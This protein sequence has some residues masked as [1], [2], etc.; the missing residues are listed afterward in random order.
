MSPLALLK[1]YLLTVL[2]ALASTTA[3]AQQSADVGPDG[4]DAEA[5]REALRNAESRDLTVIAPTISP[6]ELDRVVLNRLLQD[7]TH[8]PEMVRQQLGINADQLQDIQISLANAASFI[9]NNEMANVRA[10][11]RAWNESSLEGD[12]RIAEALDAYKARRQF[13]VDFIAM[14]YRVVVLEIESFLPPPELVRFQRY[15][16]DRRRR[17]ANAGNVVNAPIV[18]NV[19]SG[20]ETVAFHCR[21]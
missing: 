10:M 4:L 19:V 6:Q 16:E 1:Q 7:I 21:R 12:S 3:T 20:R 5:A 9:N 18:E 13:T 8:E 17:L 11:C 15:L 2:I 14:Y